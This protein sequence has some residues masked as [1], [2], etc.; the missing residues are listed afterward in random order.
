MR[1]EKGR[2]WLLLWIDE[3]PQWLVVGLPCEYCGCLGV[4]G[5]RQGGKKRS[6]RG[7]SLRVG[8]EGVVGGGRAIGRL[9]CG[10][11]GAC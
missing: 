11:L 9:R 7:Q 3:G 6:V 10:R 2:D 1:L 5:A 4:L 8:E